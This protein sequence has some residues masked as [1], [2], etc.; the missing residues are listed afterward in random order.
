MLT[1]I[2][3]IV[4]AAGKIFVIANSLVWLIQNTSNQ[5]FIRSRTMESNCIYKN[6]WWLDAFVFELT[7]YVYIYYSSNR[8]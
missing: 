6:D 1:R 4:T 7:S 8:V 2:V 3:I 5:Q